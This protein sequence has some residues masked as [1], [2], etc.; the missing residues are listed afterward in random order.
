MPGTAV[1]ADSTPLLSATPAGA[2]PSVHVTT[3]GTV[4]KYTVPL[5]LLVNPTPSLTIAGVRVRFTPVLA[6][7]ETMATDAVALPS[8]TLTFTVVPDAGTGKVAV[9]VLLTAVAFVHE[10]VPRALP[11]AVSVNEAP[12][13]RPVVLAAVIPVNS[14]T[15]GV[16]WSATETEES[17]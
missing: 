6:A 16:V 3:E 15:T 2:L 9:S 1:V 13:V 10:S 5:V 4:P 8:V 7:A 17:E 14:S 12:G 11:A